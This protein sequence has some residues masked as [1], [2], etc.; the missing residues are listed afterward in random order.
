MGT[1]S[2]SRDATVI[3]EHYEQRFLPSD[4]QP[5]RNRNDIVLVGHGPILALNFSILRP[6]P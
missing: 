1:R 2:H 3:A 6:I 5:H 4:Q